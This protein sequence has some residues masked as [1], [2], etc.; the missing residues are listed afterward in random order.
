MLTIYQTLTNIAVNEFNDVV[1]GTKFIGGTPISPNKLR[2]VLTDNSFVDIWLSVD[3]DYS[4]HW[5][6]RKQ[7]GKIYRWDNAPHH[8]QIST[9]PNHFHEGNEN[10]IVDSYLATK[11]ENA[12]REVLEFVRQHLKTT[13]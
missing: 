3:D 1:T 6:C 7:T 12:L 2:L 8:P 9:F 4:Y 10:T 13:G 11:P 5:E